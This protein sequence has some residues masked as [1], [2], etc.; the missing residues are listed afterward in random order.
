[1][2]WDI[3]AGDAVL[4]ASGGMVQTLAG[5]PLVYGKPDFANP[6]FAAWGLVQAAAKEG[7]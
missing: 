3:A 7:L 6:H 5:E 1:M 4:R 2:E